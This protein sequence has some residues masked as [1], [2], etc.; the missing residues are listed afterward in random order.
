MILK[1][2][3]TFIKSYIQLYQTIGD[4]KANSSNDIKNPKVTTGKLLANFN[5]Q[6]TS[7][8]S[9][10]DIEF[11]VFSQWGDD[12]IIQYLIHKLDIKFKTFVE[13]GVENY[14]ESNTRFLLINNN[15]AGLV[16]DGSEVHINYIKND[17]ISWGYELYAK[18]TFITK[19]NINDVLANIPFNKELG[20]L[21]IDI[22]GNDYWVWK[23][24]TVVNPIIVIVE[25]NSVFGI[26]NPWTI[27][28][29]SDFVRSR[30]EAGILF[31]GSS[32]LSLCD[33]AKEKGYSFFGCNSAGNNA[34][35]IRNDKVGNLPV[36]TPKGGFVQS[37]F[38]EAIVNG[39]RLSSEERKKALLGKTVINTRTNNVEVFS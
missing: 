30:E 11:Q 2:I 8:H 19:E 29:Q 10:E 26:E 28:Y 31:Y 38:R 23:E 33:L 21:S 12:G 32:L 3:K 27:A 34:Y 13:F 6:R 39:E 18:Q 16:L 1:K 25:Y 35:F 36:Q 22:D 17:I 14:R 37:R 7:F 20:I 24:I 5:N 4:L 15:W 9:I